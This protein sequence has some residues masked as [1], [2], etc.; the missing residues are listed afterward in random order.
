MVEPP[1][2][3]D[4]TLELGKIFKGKLSLEDKVKKSML[5]SLQNLK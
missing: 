2:P 5:C 4:D 3:L 1:T